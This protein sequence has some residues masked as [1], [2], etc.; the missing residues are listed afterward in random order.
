MRVRFEPVSVEVTPALRAEYKMQVLACLE[1]ARPALEALRSALPDK[2]TEFDRMNSW[3]NRL[4]WLLT[5]IETATTLNVGSKLI[6]EE[7]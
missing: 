4:E 3:V 5:E 2:Q 7:T 1:T 6:V